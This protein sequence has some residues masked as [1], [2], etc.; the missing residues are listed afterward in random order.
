MG[1][2]GRIRHSLVVSEPMSKVITL[3]VDIERIR[4]LRTLI[5]IYILIYTRIYTES[6]RSVKS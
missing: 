5:H 1:M 2:M 4:Q 3:R 6:S